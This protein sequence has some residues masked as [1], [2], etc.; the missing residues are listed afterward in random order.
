MLR[1]RGLRGVGHLQM[2]DRDSASST[3]STD[4]P[5]N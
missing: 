4:R 5:T 2:A 1:Q 3:L